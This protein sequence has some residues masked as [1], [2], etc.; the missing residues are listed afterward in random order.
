MLQHIAL[1]SLNVPTRLVPSTRPCPVSSSLLTSRLS[2]VRPPT[3]ACSV[4]PSPVVPN[5]PLRPATLPPPSL[6]S[7][8]PAPTQGCKGSSVR[9]RAGKRGGDGMGGDKGKE[10]CGTESERE[11]RAK[12]RV[13][14][15]GAASD[16][17][18]GGSRREEGGEAGKD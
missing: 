5:S 2:S 3:P 11:S 1:V 17:R 15:E 4:F 13:G 14:V 12:W 16:V 10:G 7:H 8:P 9:E 18:G 6:F